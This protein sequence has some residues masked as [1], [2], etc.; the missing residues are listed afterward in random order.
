MAANTGRTVGKWIKFQIED[1]GATFR[2]LPVATINGVGFDYDQMEL[3]ALQDVMHGFLPGHGTV[4][5]DIAGPFDTTAAQAASGSGVAPAL[6]G[7]HV[8][9]N[10]LPNDNTPLGFAVYFGMRQLWETGEPVFGL[11]SSAA[12]GIQVFSYNVLSDGTYTA[13]LGMYPGSAVPT[14]GTAVIS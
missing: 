5:I 9:L 4:A 2:D 13:T 8:V 1:T 12:N 7:S 6:S 11:A 14:W 10:D 3:T